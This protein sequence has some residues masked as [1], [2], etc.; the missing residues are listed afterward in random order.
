[1]S[2]QSDK[3]G[4]R[5]DEMLARQ[6]ESLVRS[7]HSTRAEEWTDPEPS[8]EDE[9]DVDLVRNADGSVGAGMDMGA[10]DV[11]GRSELARYLGISAFPGN[12]QVLVDVATANSAPDVLASLQRLPDGREYTNINDV[13]EALGAKRQVRGRSQGLGVRGAPGRRLLPADLDP[14]L[15]A[16]RDD[17]A[18]HCPQRHRPEDAHALVGN[19]DF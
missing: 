11:A 19:L 9:P 10:D 12:R 8:G 4:P 7:G 17:V 6:T 16:E 18:L 1:M 14:V 2:Q 15:P 5:E 13:W 3:H